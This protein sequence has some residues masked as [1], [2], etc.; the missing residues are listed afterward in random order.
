MVKRTLIVLS[1]T[2]TII[3]GMVGLQSVQS[4][5]LTDKDLAAL[6]QPNGPAVEYGQNQSNGGNGFVRALKAPFKAI[7]RLFGR[8][9]K[10]D[11]KLRRLSEKDVERFESAPL[12]RV[13]DATSVPSAA[14]PGI[15]MG[16]AEH[17]ERGRAL[18][19]DG[20]LNDAI[21]ELSLA[22]SKDPKL[23]G[24]YN[25]LGVAYH[26]KGLPQ[27]AHKSFEASLKIN[28]K[29]SQTLNNLG[30][31]LY[32][33]GDYKGALERLQK[34]A[35]LA[36][37]DA[38]IFNNLALT[39]S[40]LGKFDDAYKNFARAGGER[41][42]RL[43]IANRLELAGRSEEALKHYEAAR[44][45]A[46]TEQKANP[47]SLVITVAMGIKNGRVTYAAIENRR[48][49]ME[50]YEASALRIARQR[51]YPSNK[52]GQESIAVRVSTMPAS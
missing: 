45:A 15:D 50:A 26:R 18:L 31:L 19:D 21:A 17:L 13:V 5:V 24:A 23:A 20:N 39:Q 46:E 38:R 1:L 41:D 4:V 2:V 25:L 40:R 10:E 34:A 8:G 12:T 7:G 9:K 36:P 14:A 51:R 28:K 35:R 16:A 37:D 33:N 44:A 27:L 6:N 32:S 11:N 49:G 30:Y 29:N 3:L 22:T 43:N 48:A 42:G 47:N 52:H